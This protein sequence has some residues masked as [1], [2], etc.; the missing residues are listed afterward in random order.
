MT[1]RRDLAA[2]G[3]L[4]AGAGLVRMERVD[5][6]ALR[7]WTPALVATLAE[8]GAL[9]PIGVV[10]DLGG[11]LR[12]GTARTPGGAAPADARLRA[13]LRG[14]DDHVLGRLLGDPLLDAL[15]DAFA[16][17]PPARRADAVGLFAS[18]LLSRLGFRGMAVP[19]ALVRRTL[20]RPG[21]EVL[22]AG[23]SVLRGEPDEVV[24]LA[25]AYERLVAASRRTGALLVPADRF[26]IANL[27]RLAGLAQRLALAQVAEAVEALG[28]DVP[29]RIRGTSRRGPAP[30]RVHEESSYP[31]G[32]FSA[33]S[34]LGS[35]ENLVTSELV[36]MDAGQEP[37][38]TAPEVDLFDVRWAQGE[39]LYYARDE[40]L[41]VRE[42]RA[43]A[44]VLD[45]DLD[46]ARF[47]DPG[48]DWQRLVGVLAIVVLAVQRLIDLLTE[49]DLQIRV[50]TPPRTDGVAPLAAEAGLL[51][52]L[53]ADPIARG[54]VAVVTEPVA[55]TLAWATGEA[56]RAHVDV[57]C[58][59]TTAS[60]P[61]T[62]ER[63]VRVARVEVDARPAL[64]GVDGWPEVSI[65]LVRRLL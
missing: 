65:A 44:L 46:A 5:P 35:I 32:G 23:L 58:F 31:I 21:Q 25:D 8:A 10:A 51:E 16:G 19:A 2:H 38:G 60:A 34:T 50:V 20:D 26:V 41:A 40:G 11:L 4:C 59:S 37:G 33:I 49:Q 45:P 61:A 9:P 13:A 64:D 24:A 17:L 39:L 48:A 6:A 30:S 27:E 3:W 54:V 62:G 55:S 22:D 29:R 7:T 56:R 36:Y 52:L 53:L 43:I 28:R 42:R 1:E 14:W 47:R 57:V 63:R 18:I 15:A 12:H